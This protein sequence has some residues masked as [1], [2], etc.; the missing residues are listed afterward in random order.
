MG[1]QDLHYV[2]SVPGLDYCVEL[3]VFD[4]VVLEKPMMVDLDCIATSFVNYP[5]DALEYSWLI[6]DFAC[7][8]TRWPS[9][10]SPRIMTEEKIRQ[11]ILPPQIT[12]A[13][14]FPTRLFWG[15]ASAGMPAA[16]DNPLPKR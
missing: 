6:V 2:F 10:T 3:G 14:V 4:G 16:L 1:F 12:V 11:S 5:A 13:T 8:H 9:R 15:L 7:T